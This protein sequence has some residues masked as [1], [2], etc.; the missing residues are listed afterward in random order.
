MV[1]ARTCDAG[2]TR[3]LTLALTN[4]GGLPAASPIRR[5]AARFGYT[6]HFLQINASDPVDMASPYTAKI[7]KAIE[8]I[9]REPCA[10]TIVMMVD[11]FDVILL[12][13]AAEMM[14][15]FRSMRAGVV[16]AGEAHMPF[17]EG[18]NRSI[19]DSK[20]SIRG[21]AMQTVPAQ[22]VTCSKHDPQCMYIHRYLNAGGVIGY[23]NNVLRMFEEI[24]SVK[25]GGEGWRDRRL[26]C[27]E[28]KGRKCAEQWA[29]IRVMSFVPWEELN[30]TLDYES[31]LFY[32]SDFGFG[33]SL[34]RDKATIATLDPASFH[35]T[36]LA[37]PRV[38][39]TF[40]ALID[41]VFDHTPWPQTNY[42]LC[43]Q[44]E[45]TCHERHLALIAF[46]KMIVHCLAFQMDRRRARVDPSGR[47]TVSWAFNGTIDVVCRAERR[48]NLHRQCL[49]NTWPSPSIDE[50]SAIDKAFSQPASMPH[51]PGSLTCAGLQ[52]LLLRSPAL[53]DL[54]R[55]NNLSP[56]FLQ[57]VGG[58]YNARRVDHFYLAGL[59]IDHNSRWA[60]TFWS[61]YPQCYYGSKHHSG[62]A[63]LC[64]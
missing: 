56:A 32:T 8:A 64:C 61:A 62:K 60:A 38:N 15:R 2:Q 52:P 10:D 9:R 34:S 1:A 45:N 39:Q 26:A 25:V 41:E 43:K 47:G 17:N 36:G 4:P 5:S 7:P 19:F 11:A 44:H 63:T 53:Q 22:S 29:A 58:S 59:S 37:S 23:R 54:C 55:D 27:G 28:A 40:H 3:L 50:C 16:W 20:A 30:V 21:P 57:V 12:Q 6:L 42:A 46:S 35:Q 49:G 51:S 31:R 14:R 24:M 33:C 18:C 48:L 13:P